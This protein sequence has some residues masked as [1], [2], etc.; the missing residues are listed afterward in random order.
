MR[1]QHN[2][3]ALKDK[4]IR[5]TASAGVRLQKILAAAGIASRRGSEKMIESGR[6]S[7]NGQVVTQLGSRADLDR[8]DV[9]VDGRRV[10][11][12]QRRR[13]LVVNKP[14]GYVTTR[15]DPQR[16]K[17]VLDLIPRV[18]EYVYPV[19]RLD[20]HSEGLLLL[21]NDGDL[22]GRL[23]H[24]RHR[25]ERKYEAVIRGV[26]TSIELRKLAS[27]IVLDGRR[28]APADVRLLGGHTARRVDQARVRVTLREGRNRQLRR[29]F[30]AIGY[31]VVR[32][33]RTGFGPIRGQGLKLGQFRELSRDE[34]TALW[35]IVETQPPQSRP[36]SR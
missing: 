24:P 9:R 15:H 2:P 3:I 27:G 5:S 7:V 19:G 18:H 14:V 12:S 25:V 11:G 20:Y 22:A 10:G 34:T 32:L 1:P 26:P 29:M 16:R 6:V 4:F 35:R 17:T 28:T 23:T 8:D 13:Y 33:R 31:R 21:T 36:V 30:E